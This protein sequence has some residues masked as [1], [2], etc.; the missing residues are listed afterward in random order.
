M[1]YRDGEVAIYA[2]KRGL[3]KTFPHNLKSEQPAETLV[4]AFYPPE[5]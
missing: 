2:L 1:M 4:T 3:E 5:L